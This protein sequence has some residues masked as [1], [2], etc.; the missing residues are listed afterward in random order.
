[1]RLPL[2]ITKYAESFIIRDAHDTSICSI[3]FDRGNDSE[4]AIRKRMSEE[5]AE[6]LA[7]RIARMLTDEETQ[8]AADDPTNGA[9][10]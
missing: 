1:M 4:R 10:G 5:E 2:R 9:A 3:F 7:K 6:A 8:K